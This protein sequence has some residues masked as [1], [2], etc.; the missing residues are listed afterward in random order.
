MQ[1]GVGDAVQRMLL[2]MERHRAVHEEA[3]ETESRDEEDD[4]EE[5][6]D[7]PDAEVSEFEPALRYR[8]APDVS[9]PPSTIASESVLLPSEQTLIES[10]S[11]LEAA[12]ERFPRH[13]TPVGRPE[14]DVEPAPSS[15]EGC[16]TNR[17]KEDPKAVCRR[18]KR[19]TTRRRP[20]RG[21]SFEAQPVAGAVEGMGILIWRRGR[22]GTS[23]GLPAFGSVLV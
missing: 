2:R 6:Y 1:T 23:I 11:R 4:Y 14:A 16:R 8:L 9:Y 22:C 10:V 18:G 3:A 20:G 12:V 21:R 19:L 7:D 15:S 17:S 5:Y 13:R